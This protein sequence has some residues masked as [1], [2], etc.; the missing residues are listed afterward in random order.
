MF[1]GNDRS[2]GR[3]FW[4]PV[5]E[6]RDQL[7]LSRAIMA[8]VFKMGTAMTLQNF[9][10]NE[11][12]SGGSLDSCLEYCGCVVLVV[13]GIRVIYSIFERE[14]SNVKAAEEAEGIYAK[15][16]DARK[17]VAKASAARI[18]EIASEYGFN[19]TAE[20]FQSLTDPPKTWMHVRD[21]DSGA[22][23]EKAAA[24]EV[25]VEAMILRL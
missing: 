23:M 10:Y 5:Y 7:L 12:R 19:W 15:R 6:W 18:A 4:A 13:I 24:R 16:V 2:A 1:R 21:N 20:K 8:I 14:P 11:G 3:V 25:L 9:D 17:L 22:L